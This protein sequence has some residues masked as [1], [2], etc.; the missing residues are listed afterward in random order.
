MLDAR[1]LSVHELAL[2]VERTVRALCP[3][4]TGEQ[5]AP[6]RRGGL[7]DKRVIDRPADDAEVG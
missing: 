1:E 4:V 3:T 7:A 2:H 5:G 6:M